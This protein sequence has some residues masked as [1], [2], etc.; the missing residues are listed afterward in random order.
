MITQTDLDQLTYAKRL[1]ENPSLAA[2]LT[3]ALG[4]PLEKGVALLPAGWSVTVQTAVKTALDK[5]L[6]V[7]VES[8]DAGPPGKPAA[9]RLHR[10]AVTVSGAAGGA[11]GLAGLAVELPVSTT[12]MLRSI[13]SVA[14]SEGERLE[15]VEPRLAC[16]Q[17]FALGG[18]SKADDAAEAGYYAVRVA[19]ARLTAEAAEH[20]AAHGVGQ[21]GAPALLRL[22]GAVAS[23]FGVV[24]GEKA[25]AQ[26]L[27]LLGAAGGALVNNLFIA[28]FQAAA[29][30]HFIVRRLEREHGTEAVEDAY[31]RI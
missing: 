31:R 20:L 28:H 29:R 3:S 5:S 30:G 15:H 6:T 14:R 27:P 26:A 1:L 16:L 19:L 23:R 12:L 10:A 2:R 24:V 18:R 17:V 22:L 11:F 25:A 4:T 21:G 13:A 9:N 8:L 7:A